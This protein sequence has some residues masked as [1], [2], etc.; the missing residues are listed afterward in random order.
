MRGLA[1]R[2]PGDSVRPRRSSGVVVRPLNFTVRRHGY[3][4]TMGFASAPL[5]S[6][7]RVLTTI[8]FHCPARRFSRAPGAPVARR[9]TSSNVHV[10]LSGTRYLGVSR[11]LLNC[12]ASGELR[13]E[14]S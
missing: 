10:R 8:D 12:I 11:A 3:A 5:A 14:A 4:S 9:R 7:C 1:P 2:A 6:L 13:S